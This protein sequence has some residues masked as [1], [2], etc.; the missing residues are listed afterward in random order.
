[1]APLPL[2]LL[3]WLIAATAM[4]QP[5]SA[6]PFPLAL[7]FALLAVAVATSEKL[8]GGAP[9]VAGVLTGAAAAWRLDFGAYA[10]AAC[11][12]AVALRPGERLSARA[13]VGAAALGAV[14]VLGYGPF[15]AAAGAD[16]AWDALVAKACATASTGRCRSPSPTTA[17]SA[18]SAT[19][20]TCSTSTSRCILV[21]GTAVA[22]AITVAR[23]LRERV[24]PWRWAAWVVLATGVRPVPL[25]RTDPFHETPL[26]VALAI[27]LAACAAW[28]LRLPAGRARLAAAG[29]S[30]ALLVLMAVRGNREP[31][32]RAV[33]AARPRAACDL[34]IA[35]GVEAEPIEARALPEA[36]RRGAASSSRRASRS[37][38]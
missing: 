14:V 37:T 34:A 31:P 7:L 11:I 26:R 3:A 35:D 29:A 9:L 16:D 28:A 36:V 33:L 6:N 10:A 20:R 18:R 21:V 38:S 17:A 23:W 15:F 19:R 30:L 13:C 4:A 32:L 22:A 27:A 12:V 1:M 24:P 25:S 8:A 2:A 5:L